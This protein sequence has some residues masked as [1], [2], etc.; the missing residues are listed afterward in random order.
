MLQVL[1]S[2]RI[3]P[4][5]HVFHED[6]GA[7][8]EEDDKGF[9][10]F[11]RRYSRLPT[12]HHLQGR[13]DVP[14]PSNVRERSHPSTQCEQTVSEKDAAFDVVCEDVEDGS[15]VLDADVSSCEWLRMYA[16]LTPMPP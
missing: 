15:S 10:E 9:G 1:R 5:S 14:R 2:P 4:S 16:A 12:A 7:A 6:V 8:V 3:A 13:L 11:G